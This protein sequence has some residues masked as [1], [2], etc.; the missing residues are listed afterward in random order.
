M[1][2]VKTGMGISGRYRAVL[3][4][5]KTEEVIQD[6]GWFDNLITNY[7]MRAMRDEVYY[8]WAYAHLGSGTTAPAFSDT[9]LEQMAGMTYYAVNYLGIH[10]IERPGQ[11]FIADGFVVSGASLVIT[12]SGAINGTYTIDEVTAE[13]ISVVQQFPGLGDGPSYP[14]VPAAITTVL[15][16]GAA[17]VTNS[18]T[19]GKN[20]ASSDDGWVDHASDPYWWIRRKFR[21]EVGESTG[22]I[23]EILVSRSSTAGGGGQGMSH[24]LFP[25][26]IEKGPDQILDV[27]HEVRNYQTKTDAT[28]TVLIDGVTYNYLVRGSYIDSDLSW[29][30]ASSREY[31]RSG[32]WTLWSGTAGT[33]YGNPG[34]SAEF[35]NFYEGTGQNTY[36]LVATGT[37]YNDFSIEVGLDWGN[38]TDGIKTMIIP[39]GNCRYQLQLLRASDGK[40][41]IKTYEERF[42][43]TVRVGLYRH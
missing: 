19:N 6:T 18:A 12:G 10:R 26:P 2:T 11:D 5:G 15:T 36:Q 27:Y 14:H 25:A 37:Y 31:L 42:T 1:S 23:N 21:W 35:P 41:V 8:L 16:Q 32:T 7:G 30:P 9:S 28:G 40:G 17:V 43:L 34:G 22:T 4:D 20:P 29:N 39:T 24:A 3:R 13:Y 33:L 38:F